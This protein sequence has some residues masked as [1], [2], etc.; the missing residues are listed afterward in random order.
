VSRPRVISTIHVEHSRGWWCAF[1]QLGPGGVDGAVA[2]YA[3]EK[4]DAVGRLVDFIERHRPELRLANRI[5]I[6]T[7]ARP[8]AGDE[9]APR[10]GGNK[11]R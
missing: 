8:E 6:V 11:S 1:V 3:S 7:A 10:S 9:V 2:A 4:F 5:E